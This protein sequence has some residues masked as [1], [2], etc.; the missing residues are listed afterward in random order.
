MVHKFKCNDRNFI[1]DVPSGSLLEVDDT[2]FLCFGE[3]ALLEDNTD[4]QELIDKGIIYTED[5]FDNYQL[6]RG[7][8]PIK[9][10]CLNIAQS[11]NL[12]CRYCFAGDGNYGKDE[13]MSYETA[14]SAVDFVVQNSYNRENIEV[15]FFGGEPLLNWDVIKKTV[16]YALTIPNKIFHFTI[17]TNGILL[18]D[19]KM[20]FIN[21]HMEN[22]V[23]SIDGRKETND[24]NRRTKSGKGTYDI[25]VKNL[26]KFAKARGDKDYYIRGTYTRD[27]LDFGEDIKHLADL[28][29][30]N[31][32]L[33]HAVS[34][35]QDYSITKDNLQEIFSEYERFSKIYVNSDYNFFHFMLD[36][37]AS[38][39][40]IK[41]LS[42]CGAGCEYVA[43]SPN[44]DVYPCHQFV[45]EEHMRLGNL[46]TGI[47]NTELQEKIKNISVLTKKDCKKCWARYYCSGGCHANALHYGD[48]IDGTHEISCEIQK[49]RIECALYVK[50]NKKS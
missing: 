19:D 36:D 30:K 1:L 47:T 40:T 12:R 39:C 25:L 20:E 43:V 48:G 33:E 32:S 6:R 29:F 34:E 22:L 11:C 37:A 7:D 4:I 14:K 27:N 41:R 50:A 17:T 42:G 21:E 18:D 46:K 45:G 35:G 2:S 13:L 9:A 49:K 3:D 31:I 26:L 44:G 5:K 10:L 16:L 8:V 24:K 23:L 15:D 28:G 38:P